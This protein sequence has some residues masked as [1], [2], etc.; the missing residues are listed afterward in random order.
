[1]ELNVVFSWRKRKTIWQRTTV[2]VFVEPC[3]SPEKVIVCIYK[4]MFYK[5]SLLL[6]ETEDCV[7][8]LYF[9]SLKSF[10]V[11]L[12]IVVEKIQYKTVDSSSCF[13]FFSPCPHF[14][15]KLHRKL[16]LLLKLSTHCL[17][18]GSSNSQFSGSGLVSRWIPVGKWYCFPRVGVLGRSICL[19]W[20]RSCRWR[21]PSSSSFTL[22]RM[23]SGGSS[24]SLLG[25][26][27][28]R[29][30]A[31]SFIWQILGMFVATNFLD[32]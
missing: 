27:P 4:Y 18:F 30:G 23:D 31:T 24:V 32:T 5:W 10:Y 3:F 2:V 1:M 19:L 14:L 11:I 15:R 6:S 17:S 9:C 21:H 29:T 13:D 25:S 7:Q 22:T 20:R 26:T 28:S 12:Y 8:I 16:P